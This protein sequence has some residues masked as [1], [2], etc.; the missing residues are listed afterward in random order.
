MQVDEQRMIGHKM[1]IGYVFSEENLFN[2]DDL[3][4]EYSDYKGSK[5]PPL[6]HT[7]SLV[8]TKE[9]AFLSINLDIFNSMGDSNGKN[10]RGASPHLMGD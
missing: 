7:E 6:K 10:M 2:Q 9:S 3:E 5:K 8:T 1:G 4:Q